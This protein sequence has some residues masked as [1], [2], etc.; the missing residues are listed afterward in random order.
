[1]FLL[2]AF[3]NIY[4]LIL[5]LIY[6]LFK[7]FP[8]K[9]KKILFLS[10]Q[11]NKPSIDFRMLIIEIKKNYPD[12]EIKIITKRVEKRIKDFI[13]KNTFSIFYQMYH[14]ATSSVCVIDGYNMS[15][16]VLKHKKSLKIIQ[17]WHSLGA[18]KKFGHQTLYK[19]RNKKFAKA[20]RMHKNYDLL[21]SSSKETT[22]YF[23]MAFNYPKEKFIN[24]GL[25]RIDYL[26]S[27]TKINQKKIY[28]KY[29]E[30]KG[31]KII[32]YTPTFRSN[33]HEYKIDSLINAIDF[34]KYVLIVKLHPC[35]N[36]GFDLKNTYTCDEF[37]SLQLLSIANFVIT[38]YSAISIEAAILNK[39]VFIYSYD[40]DEYKKY[41][42]INIDLYKEFKGYVFKDATKLYKCLSEEKYNINVIKNYKEKY[43]TSTSKMVTS[44]LANIIVEMSDCSVEIHKS[45]YIKYS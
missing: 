42:G 41:P 5:N 44:E 6:L 8:T 29:P 3:I 4:I 12:Y 43:V 40:L 25:P 31:R 1:M 7:F 18:I 19:E 27:K 30:L 23:S 15:V 16:S 36:Y 21:I 38:D 20:M 35:I 32:L 45:E 17:I 13:T 39:P 34:N 26:L 2:C 33:G 9:K 14:L 10:R 24:C 22:K 11:T 28:L 37:T